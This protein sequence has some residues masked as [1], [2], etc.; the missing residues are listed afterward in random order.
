MYVQPCC[1][2]KELPQL[3]R[4]RPF[5]FFQSNGDWTVK[6]LMKA[7]AYLVPDA[8]CLLSIPEVDVYLLRLLHMYLLKGWYRNM[9]LVTRESQEA[10]VRSVFGDSL[11]NVTYTSNN[12]VM[13][14]VFA[15]SNGNSRLLIQGPLLTEIDFTLCQ[16]AG[17]YGTDSAVFYGGIEA[18]IAKVRTGARILSDDKELK[19]FLQK[20]L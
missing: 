20:K 6:D 3:L 9:V 1:I 18:L 12:Q 15:L 4:E 13:D 8:T 7:V 2:E 17:Y 10:L 11:P 14:G 5:T 19:L 16:Y